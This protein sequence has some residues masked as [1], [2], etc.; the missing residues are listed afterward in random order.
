MKSGARELGRVIVRL[1]FLQIDSVNI[2]A[3]HDSESAP[4]QSEKAFHE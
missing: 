1:G 3:G 4:A 2:L